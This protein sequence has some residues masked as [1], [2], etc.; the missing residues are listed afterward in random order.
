MERPILFLSRAT[1][2][3]EKNYEAT[4]MELSCIAWA[5]TQ[6]NQYLEGSKV[7][8]FSYHKSI[9][10]VLSSSTLTRYSTRIDKARM[11]FIPWLDNI[12]VKYRARRKIAHVDALSWV[13]DVPGRLASDKGRGGVLDGNQDRARIVAIEK[14]G[15]GPEPEVLERQARKME[16]WSENMKEAKMVENVEETKN[17]EGKESPEDEKWTQGESVLYW[18]RCHEWGERVTEKDR[19]CKHV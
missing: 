11:V 5:F 17:V 4:E 14:V 6:L 7:V 13:V 8:I 19:I 1:H 9:Y 2:A 3:H 18:G 15:D 16:K 12:E 10:S